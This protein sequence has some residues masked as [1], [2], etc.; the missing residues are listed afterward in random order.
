MVQVDLVLTHY[1]IQIC[2]SK[3]SFQRKMNCATTIHI[4]ERKILTRLNLTA[5]YLLE[6]IYSLLFERFIF[7][8][9]ASVDP[10]VFCIVFVLIISCTSSKAQSQT[11]S[12]HSKIILRII[13]ST[14]H[15]AQLDKI[16][17]KTEN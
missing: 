5:T 13:I 15:L 12:N 6:S 8:E 1:K 4:R 11:L 10:F 2:E 9:L 16:Q 3:Y 14:K 17:S 7:V